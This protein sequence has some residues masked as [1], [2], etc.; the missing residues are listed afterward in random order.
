[1]HLP[2]LR[3]ECDVE[4]FGVADQ[5][6]GLIAFDKSNGY[7]PENP[8]GHYK[9][10]LQDR[11]QRATAMMIW[12]LA[13]IQDGQN[14]RNAKLSGAVYSESED[15]ILHLPDTGVLEFDYFEVKRMPTSF[16]VVE[17]PQI[18]SIIRGLKGQ[19]GMLPRLQFLGILAKERVFR[20][21]DLQHIL[22]CF[23]GAGFK[24]KAIAHLWGSIWDQDE[25]LRTATTLLGPNGLAELKA[26]LGGSYAFNRHN[27]TGHYVLNLDNEYDQMVIRR[28]KEISSE[29]RKTRQK[30][31]L[32]DLSQKGNGEGWRN[33]TLDEEPIVIDSN[34]WKLP[35]DGIL[36]FDFISFKRPPAQTPACSVDEFKE[37]IS[38]IV[39]ILRFG[40]DGKSRRRS[41]SSRVVS[42][43]SHLNLNCVFNSS[44]QS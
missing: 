36:E 25:V 19:G 14:I 6:D 43:V 16:Q 31:E 3:S 23:D 38:Q 33:E 29:E 18:P 44:H 1:M 27:A 28:L 24:M 26:E 37:F 41:R 40:A 15:S 10:D 8:T 5:G 34:T 11:H 35:T 39:A 4:W 12:E 9:L 30:N 13:R 20:C 2:T 32:L 21:S 7:D 42:Q 17:D 22:K